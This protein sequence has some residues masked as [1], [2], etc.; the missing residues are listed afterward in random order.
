MLAT[1]S[2]PRNASFVSAVGAVYGQKIH[3]ESRPVSSEGGRGQGHEARES[4]RS[5]LTCL[6]DVPTES[7][8]G[9][10]QQR[11]RER[12]RTARRRR[13]AIGAPLP[14]DRFF[15]LAPKLATPAHGD[16]LKSSMERIHPFMLDRPPPKTGRPAWRLTFPASSGDFVG[17]TRTSSPA[18]FM[19]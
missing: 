8:C 14:T 11:R 4:G 3:F 16:G 13:R 2:T 10:Y 7:S 9:W 6:V 18:P 15:R 5:T 19:C 17:E 12:R 1:R